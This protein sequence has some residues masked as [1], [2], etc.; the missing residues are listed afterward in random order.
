MV[1]KGGALR[2][3]LL[4][5]GFLDI[6]SACSQISLNLRVLTKYKAFHIIA[7]LFEFA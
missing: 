4:H 2:E 7:H 5:L 3:S 6:I 1:Q